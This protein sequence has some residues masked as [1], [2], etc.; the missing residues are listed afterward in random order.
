[1]SNSTLQLWNA[2]EFSHEVLRRHLPPNAR[3][4]DTTAGNG[5]DT[6]FLLDIADDGGL[7]LAIDIQQSAVDATIAR[8]AAHPRAGQAEVVMCAHSNLE[9]LLLE[10]SWLNLHGAI[11]NCGYLPGGDKSIR[12]NA[13]TTELALHTLLK[14]LAKGGVLCVVCYTG[15]DGGIEERD[16]VRDLCWGLSKD[17][18]HCSHYANLGRQNAPECFIIE[19]RSDPND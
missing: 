1:M 8:I 3:V 14:F 5:Y 4:L 15:H 7:V 13:Q 10:K 6:R 9:Q 19:R 18:Y 12:T 16:V 11:M 2:V 17:D